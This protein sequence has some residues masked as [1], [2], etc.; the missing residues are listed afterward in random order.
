MKFR[1]GACLFLVFFPEKRNADKNGKKQA[2]D[3]NGGNNKTD[4]SLSD[5]GEEKVKAENP[6][7]IDLGEIYIYKGMQ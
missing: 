2:Y 1:P 3:Q 4:R 7:N 6:K 5:A